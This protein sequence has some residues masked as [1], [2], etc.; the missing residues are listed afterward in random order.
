MKTDE[1]QEELKKKKEKSERKEKKER[2]EVSQ[3]EEEEIDE[4]TEEGGEREEGDHYG[5]VTAVIDGDG[6]GSRGWHSTS[7]SNVTRGGP[8]HQAGQVHLI[9]HQQ[10]PRGSL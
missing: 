9:R 2:S 10:T 8:W 1:T 5:G 6:R 7:L 3:Q 4:E